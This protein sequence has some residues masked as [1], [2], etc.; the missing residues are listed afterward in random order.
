MRPPLPRWTVHLGGEL[1]VQGED[2]CYNRFP[3]RR[4]ALI[5]MRLAVAPGQPLTRDELCG[6]LWPDEA[7]PTA[8]ILLRNELSRLRR[9]LGG[10]AEYLIAAGSSISLDQGLIVNDTQV[11]QHLL[12][13][14]DAQEETSLETSRAVLDL[15]AAPLLVREGSEEWLDVAIAKRKALRRAATSAFAVAACLHARAEMAAE[16]VSEALGADPKDEPVVLA[17]MERALRDG[18]KAE[19]ARYY[20]GLVAV[21]SAQAGATPNREIEALAANALG[22]T[23]EPRG[24]AEKIP[25]SNLPKAIRPLIGRKREIE[26]LLSLLA[27]ASD[28]S[29]LVTLGGLGGIG[30][31]SLALE[32]ASRLQAVYEGRVWFFDVSQVSEGNQILDALLDQLGVER[33]TQAD[34]PRVLSTIT[35]GRASLFVID[36]F[37]QVDSEGDR[38]LGELL[39]ANPRLRVLT[40]SRR[41]LAVPGEQFVPLPPLD[42][43]EG[44]E[45]YLQGAPATPQGQELRSLVEMLDGIPLAINL[46]SSSGGVLMPR[47]SMEQMKSR[48]EFLVD[49]AEAHPARH[50]RL[51]DTIEWSFRRLDEEA[52]R[53]FVALAVFRG[54]WTLEAA[55]AVLGLKE[56]HRTMDRLVASSFVVST[57]GPGGLRFSFLETLR[58]FAEAKLTDSERDVLEAKHFAYFSEF[59]ERFCSSDFAHEYQ[60]ASGSIRFE[61]ANVRQAFEWAL[62]HDRSA[63]VALVHRLYRFWSSRGFHTDGLQWMRE[64]LQPPR[65]D[66]LESLGAQFGAGVLALN[67]G[68]VGEARKYLEGAVE[69]SF[70]LNDL[71]HRHIVLGRLAEV[72]RLEGRYKESVALCR[73]CLDYFDLE[74]QSYHRSFVSNELALSLTALGEFDEA[75]EHAE[76]VVRRR[77]NSPHGP[78][79]AEALATLGKVTLERGELTRARAALMESAEH[80]QGHEM[81][82][83][84]GK[85]SELLAELDLDEGLADDAGERLDELEALFATLGNAV[86]L[87][88]I[89]RLRARWLWAGGRHGEAEDLIFR[90][91]REPVERPRPQSL[92]LL[93]SLAILLHE[94]QPEKAGAILSDCDRLREVLDIPRSQLE[95]RR[96]VGIPV[97][98]AELP[99]QSLEASMA[100]WLAARW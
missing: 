12:E 73:Q 20:H 13:S 46:A 52:R 38:V 43:E 99:I 67:Q 30:K 79:L 8:K 100:Y 76:A 85:A 96:L 70:V 40:T 98:P 94:K 3:T 41:R 95:A 89:K 78:F 21:L 9:A 39:Q 24:P 90:A 69:I 68:L 16:A 72:E 57:P 31:T 27:P 58:E 23:A 59:V 66:S 87:D 37:E 55:G 61:Y 60:K 81:P 6:Y 44:V 65:L 34:L 7:V 92:S 63:A 18:R 10:E 47:D 25:A 45:L 75:L 49:H 74:T 32:A 62:G 29:R 11:A 14:F 56:P 82:L 93:D 86:D 53:S 97:A 71:F 50:H 22:I 54:G 42:A 36:N 17:A 2:V 88:R 91:M 84:H 77:V 83:G 26:T 33:N 64:A 28:A 80:F 35:E 48:F 4:S 1:R 19:A 5:L 15:L 51:W